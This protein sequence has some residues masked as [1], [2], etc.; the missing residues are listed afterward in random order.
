MNCMT[1]KKENWP[2]IEIAHFLEF[3]DGTS[4][5]NLMSKSDKICH[6]LRQNDQ[7]IIKNDIFAHQTIYFLLSYMA[8]LPKSAKL[9]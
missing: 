2:E 3:E 5:D 8:I 6:F 9:S 1:Y 4:S 7:N